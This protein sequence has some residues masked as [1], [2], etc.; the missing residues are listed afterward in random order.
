LCGV[1][2][3]LLLFC[4]LVMH[5]TMKKLFFNIIAFCLLAPGAHAQAPGGKEEMQRKTQ[6]L[7]R[8]IETLRQTQASV[9]KNKKQT[10]GVLRAIERKIDI[11]TEVIN[12]IKGEVF[13]VE[14]DIL[15]TYRDIDTLK[16]ELNT[17]KAQYAQSIVYTYKNR[18]SYDFLN[19][20]FSAAAFSDAL[21]RMNYLKTYRSFRTQKAAQIGRTKLLLETKV[22]SLTGKKQDK[23]QALQ[24]QNAQM[25]VLEQDKR[26]KDLVVSQLKAKENDLLVAMRRKEDERRKIQSAIAAVIKREKDEALKRERAEAAKRKAA[27]DAAQKANPSAA[28]GTGNSGTSSVVVKAPPKRTREASVLENTPEGLVSSQNFEQNKGRMPW[29]VEKALVRLHYGNN[30]I[31]GKTR[32]LT[33]PSS[34]ITIETVEGAPV[35]AIFEGEVA[36]V[37]NIGNMTVIIIKHGKYFSTYSNLQSPS[38]SKGERVST[39]Q[40]IG[41]A[42]VGDDGVGSIDLQIDDDKRSFNPEVWV[43]GR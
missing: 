23:N 5:S 6:E 43:R 34:G 8:E 15:H 24:E 42:G 37:S 14:K 41:R 19:F 35:K 28:S 22:A 26:E 31:P 38:V 36:G 10:L 12:S 17:L 39:G 1:P 11:R 2:R 40:P 4:P 25:S 3:G 20:L 18:S 16:R 9:Q 30:V 27:Q 33:I 21:K 29:P 7:L 13:Y 32:N